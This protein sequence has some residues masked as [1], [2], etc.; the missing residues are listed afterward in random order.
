ML[1]TLIKYLS[2]PK[3]PHT[4]NQKLSQAEESTYR[5]LAGQI[6]WV[7]QG[8]RPN[9]A[10]EM[11]DLST[12]SKITTVNNLLQAIKYICKLKAT[13][14]FLRFSYLGPPKEW[15]LVLF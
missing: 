13:P 10:F 3:D 6:N 1:K 11:V 2:H 5:S 7:V 9:L 15:T 8:T 12:K 14:S 4:K